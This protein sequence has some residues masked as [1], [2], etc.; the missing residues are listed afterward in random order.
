[1][2][3][4]LHGTRVEPGVKMAMRCNN[5]ACRNETFKVSVEHRQVDKEHIDRLPVRLHCAKCGKP[6]KAWITNLQMK[7]LIAL[8]GGQLTAMKSLALSF[9]YLAKVKRKPWW[10]FW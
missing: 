7:E 6:A 8:H 4:N 1:M 9:E 3:G 5:P 10:K 2:C